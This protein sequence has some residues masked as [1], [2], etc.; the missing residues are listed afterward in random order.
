MN[1]IRWI[2]HIIRKQTLLRGGLLQK[3]EG[4]KHH[5]KN[6]IKKKTIITMAHGGSKEGNDHH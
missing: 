5:F 6:E 3:K 1:I 4:H 2:D